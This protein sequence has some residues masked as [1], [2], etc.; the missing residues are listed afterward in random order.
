[1][2]REDAKVAHPRPE[3]FD[4]QPFGKDDLC[5]FETQ[6]P[7]GVDCFFRAGDAGSSHEILCRDANLAPVTHPATSLQDEALA[8][9]EGQRALISEGS[10]GDP[11]CR[12][13]QFR[14]WHHPKQVAIPVIGGEKAHAGFQ[15][16]DRAGTCLRR[17]S[18]AARKAAVPGLRTVI[19]PFGYAMPLRGDAQGIARPTF[20]APD[21]HCSLQPARRQS[22]RKG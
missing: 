15:I 9:R 17:H 21:I 10:G 11:D 3:A 22:S 1:M 5:S 4:A 20:I 13:C 12:D 19:A 14:P 18:R 2:P 8:G 6:L 16:L 7:P